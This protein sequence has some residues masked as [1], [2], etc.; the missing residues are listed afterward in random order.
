[1]MEH[2]LRAVL[3]FLLFWIGVAV[4]VYGLTGP[5]GLGV[6]LILASAVMGIQE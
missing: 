1:M 4:V 6:V 2:Q 3:T 5:V